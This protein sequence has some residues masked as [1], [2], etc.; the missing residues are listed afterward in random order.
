MLLTVLHLL[1]YSGSLRI[2]G[3]DISQIHRQQ[4]RSRITTLPQDAIELAGSVRENLSRSSRSSDSALSYTPPPDAEIIEALTRVGMWD[5][6]VAR[7][8]LDAELSSIGLSQ[9]QSQLL[10]L[11]GAIIHNRQTGS[12]VVLV[13][14]ATS[15]MDQ[16]TDAQ[17]Q[18]VMSEV[19]AGCTVLTI[20]HRLETLREADV[21]LKLDEGRLVEVTNRT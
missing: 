12:K 21:I 20:A 1:D 16:G 4:L 15:N 8:G 11:A 13:D 9:G 7:G 2:D 3:I 19:F 14:E 18:A 10:N 6:I 17:M 5:H